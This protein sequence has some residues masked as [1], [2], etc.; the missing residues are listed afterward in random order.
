MCAMHNMIVSS[1]T[2]ALLIAFIRDHAD[3]SGYHTIQQ[4]W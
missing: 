2:N 4:K 1:C 3:F